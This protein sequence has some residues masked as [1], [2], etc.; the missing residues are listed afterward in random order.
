MHTYI[1]AYT[2]MHAYVHAVDLEIPGGGGGGYIP[3]KFICFIAP[4]QPT[5]STGITKMYSIDMKLSKGQVCAK[6]GAHILTKS[7]VCLPHTMHLE[8]PS[9]HQLLSFFT[10]LCQ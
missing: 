2:Y 5:H 1:D 6:T 8:L 7:S 3:M 10:S 4:S 9:Q